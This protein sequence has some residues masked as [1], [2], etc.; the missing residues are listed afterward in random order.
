MANGAVEILWQAS[1]DATRPVVN[2]GYGRRDGSPRQEVFPVPT[3]DPHSYLYA[4]DLDSSPGGNPDSDGDGVRDNQDNCTNIPNPDQHDSNGDGFGNICDADFNQTCMVDLT[5]L[6]VMRTDFLMPGD[7]DTDL[8]GDGWTNL[9]DLAVMR[10]L[11]L[12]PPGP[13][14]L[15]NNCEQ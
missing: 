6:A 15:L 10:N 7:L 4:I 9:T 2:T 5:D 1:S 8:N 11:F 13:S 3:G 14:G 12:L